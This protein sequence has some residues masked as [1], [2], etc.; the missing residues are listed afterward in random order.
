VGDGTRK[1]VKKTVRIIN[2]SGQAAA[3]PPPL[4]QGRPWCGVTRKNRD[5]T[6]L[7]GIPRLPHRKNSDGLAFLKNHT[8]IAVL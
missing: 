7:A 4:T 6:C 3:C 8:I 1:G 2:P 5:K